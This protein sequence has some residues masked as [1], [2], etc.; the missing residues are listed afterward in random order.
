MHRHV[1]PCEHAPSSQLM[2]SHTKCMKLTEKYRKPPPQCTAAT[3]DG[4]S[5][6]NKRQFLQITDNRY[7]IHFHFL[8]ERIE[9][10]QMQQVFLSL[11]LPHVTRAPSVSAPWELHTQTSS[12]GCT[13]H[14]IGDRELSI[15]SL[16]Q[17][18]S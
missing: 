5:L 3:R 8:N 14:L 9:F 2:E 15:M 10:V 12:R 17:A 7:S 11:C 1:A 13:S 6:P 4:F 18:F 16:V